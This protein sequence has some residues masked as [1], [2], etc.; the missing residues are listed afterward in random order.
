VSADNR[1]DLFE[2]CLRRMLRRNLDGHFDKVQP[3]RV[4]YFKT[5]E[6][7]P[8][9]LSLLSAL[10]WTGNA[11][12]AEASEAFRKGARQLNL[13]KPRDFPLEPQ[14]ESTD[15]ARIDKI[16]DQLS[17]AGPYVKKN[18]LFACAHTVAADGKILEPEHELL[19]AIAD[20]LDLPVP[21]FI[22][23]RIR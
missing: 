13:S 23:Q 8:E 19:R 9:A 18:L 10:A 5:E 4:A 15:I 3:P 6:V 21:P 20:A 17:L 14:G 22:H 1:V 7:L 11:S 2:F 12:K 16:L